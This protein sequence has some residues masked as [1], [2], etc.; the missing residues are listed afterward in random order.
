M[1]PFFLKKGAGAPFFREKGVSA[2][3]MIPKCTDRDLLRYR[4]GKYQEIPTD[5]DQKIPIR[6]TTLIFTELRDS[7]NL[8]VL[9]CQFFGFWRE[10]GFCFTYLC[11]IPNTLV[12][13]PPIF[14]V[15]AISG[16][17]KRG[18]RFFRRP[19]TLLAISRAVDGFEQQLFNPSHPTLPCT[20]IGY[21][22]L[23]LGCAPTELGTSLSRCKFRANLGRIL[24]R[25]RH[26]ALYLAHIHLRRIDRAV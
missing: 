26:W 23:A 13:P 19:T 4:Y 25:R 6:Y 12:G 14:F 2:K 5:T 15:F 17:Q 21:L 7:L 8:V 1:P 11:I 20:S 10:I 9:L 22:I 16:A 24:G 18:I 3:K